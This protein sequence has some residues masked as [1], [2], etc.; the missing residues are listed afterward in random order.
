MSKY[1]LSYSSLADVYAIA[2]EETG[3][4]KAEL[5]KLAEDLEQVGIG[6]FDEE[7]FVIYD[8]G[9]GPEVLSMEDYLTEKRG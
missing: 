6:Y 3:E 7:E 9:Y 1:S 4:T 5:L 2:D 8:S